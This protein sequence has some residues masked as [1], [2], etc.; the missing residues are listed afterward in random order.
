[1]SIQIKWNRNNIAATM[2]RYVPTVKN[3]HSPKYHHQESGHL[4]SLTAPRRK[5]HQQQHQHQHHQNNTSSDCLNDIQQQNY[6]YAYYDPSMS[7]NS[8]NISG[9]YEEES[10]SSSTPPPPNSMRALLLTTRRNKTERNCGSYGYGS[11]S[12][13]SAISSNGSRNHENVYEEIPDSEKHKILM[14]TEASIVSLNQRM[15]DEEIQL[16][17]NRHQRTLGE[18]NLSV[19][20]MLMPDAESEENQGSK[21]PFG[22]FAG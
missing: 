5:H 4:T 11:N 2:E 17:Q 14:K 6:S 7:I 10:G 13:D 15:V 3:Q 12:D 9:F 20:E 22:I 8:Q 19:E 21:N 1:M 18:L 16:V